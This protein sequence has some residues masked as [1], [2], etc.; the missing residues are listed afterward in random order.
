MDPATLI[1]AALS[2][3]AV[4]GLKDAVTSAIG[5]AYVALRGLVSNRVADQPHGELALDQFEAR[6]DVWREQLRDALLASGAADDTA[7]LAA[8]TRLQELLDAEGA[9]SGT[10]F[11]TTFSGNV[12]GTVQG[13]H[14]NVTMNFDRPAEPPKR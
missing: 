3:G 8:A 13:N 2:A 10:T 11:H 7:V 5:D 4:A 1:L 14:A 9:G 6:P 12:Q